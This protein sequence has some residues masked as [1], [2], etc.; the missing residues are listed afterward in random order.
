MEVPI[1]LEVMS[2][3]KKKHQLLVLICAIPPLFDYLQL[4]AVTIMLD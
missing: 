3:S 2:I 4:Y 1:D